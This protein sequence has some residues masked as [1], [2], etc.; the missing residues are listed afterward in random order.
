MTLRN[1][2][3]PDRPRFFP[4]KR[5]YNIFCRSIHLCGV[6]VYTGGIFFN[7]PPETLFSSYLLIAVS[8]LA[9]IGADLYSNG[10]WLFQN[11]GFLVI[12]KLL[13]LGVLTHTGT[14]SAWTILGI[15]VFSSIISH[16]PAPFRHYSIYHRREI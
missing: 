2:F 12:I 16:G 7:I 9:M 15:I 1:L 11:C 6:A 3:F 5:W 13:L 14:T 4:G 8:G 10:K